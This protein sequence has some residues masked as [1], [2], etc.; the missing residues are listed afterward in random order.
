MKRTILLVVMVVALAQTFASAEI[1]DF[2]ANGFTY[3]LTLNLQAP[4]E[5]VYQRLLTIGNWCNSSHTYSGE[6]HNLD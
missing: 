4:P 2:A 5:M 3:K 6:A 1:A